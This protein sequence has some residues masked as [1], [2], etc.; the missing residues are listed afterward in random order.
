[1]FLDDTKFIREVKSDEDCIIL[2]GDLDKLQ[3]WSDTKL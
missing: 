2:Q 3:S 1:M